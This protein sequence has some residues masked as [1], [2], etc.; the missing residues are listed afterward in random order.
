MF[1]LLKENVNN[2]WTLGGL[3]AEVKSAWADFTSEVDEIKVALFEKLSALNAKRTDKEDRTKVYQKH[4]L[5]VFGVTTYAINNALKAIEK[6]GE[7][8]YEATDEVEN[9]DEENEVRA[10][11]FFEELG[12][13]SVENIF[14]LFAAIEQVE[15]IHEELY[16]LENED[17]EESDEET[18]EETHEENHYQ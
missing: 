4:E 13:T 6:S 14:T 11:I 2:N 12:N 18:H 10:N 16:L 3:P 8:I 9:V 7:Y 15:L 1:N 5:I 17:D